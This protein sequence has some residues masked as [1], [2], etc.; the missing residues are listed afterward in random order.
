MEENRPRYR[1]DV[2][3]VFQTC[4]FSALCLSVLEHT[5]EEATYVMLVLF[6]GKEH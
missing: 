6:G 2:I 4:D 5:G 3:T 1:E